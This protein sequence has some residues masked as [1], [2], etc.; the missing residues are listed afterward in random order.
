MAGNEAPKIHKPPPPSTPRL[1]PWDAV[2]ELSN[3][4]DRLIGVLEAKEL[5][6]YPGV[7]GVPGVPGEIKTQW[8]AKPTKVILEP[9]AVRAAG[10][11]NTEMLNW[12]KGKRLVIKVTSTLD[13]AIAVQA[14]GN[15]ENTVHG[16]VNI[17]APLPCAAFSNI[18]VG[19]AWD[20]WHPYIGAIITHAVAP[21]VGIVKV[22]AVIQE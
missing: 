7:P 5:P 20:D 4:L 22:E 16:A 6:E 15:I 12:T 9:S 8:V 1:A 14:V 18:T 21:T 17:N 11:T 19:L 2:Q 10:T 13:Q 3:R